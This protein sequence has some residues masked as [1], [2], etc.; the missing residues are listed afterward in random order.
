MGEDTVVRFQKPGTGRDAL[1]ELLR[2]GAQRLIRQAIEAEAIKSMARR[3]L[4]HCWAVPAPPAVR[5]WTVG[6]AWFSPQSST[7]C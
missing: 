3:P 6:P 5:P 1:T 4:G 2:E 7:F